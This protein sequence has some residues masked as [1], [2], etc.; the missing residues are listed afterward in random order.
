MSSHQNLQSPMGPMAYDEATTSIQY[1]QSSLANRTR[2]FLHT[3]VPRTTL[4]TG[5][6]SRR[7]FPRFS[8]G[9]RIN[10]S[11]SFTESLCFFSPFFV[12]CRTPSGS[13]CASGSWVI[14]IYAWVVEHMCTY[15]YCVIYI[16]RKKKISAMDEAHR[17]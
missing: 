1:L 15:V 16:L 5:G 2:D 17:N 14:C 13:V 9:S 11:R 6:K 8:N 3:V 7:S 4:T 12:D 10:Y